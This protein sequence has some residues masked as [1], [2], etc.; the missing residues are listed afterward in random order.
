MKKVLKVV[1]ILLLVL[2]VAGA[3]GGTCYFF[4]TR[5]RAN[6]DVFDSFS[7]FIYGSKKEE[8]DAKLS[9]VT[10]FTDDRFDLVITT[11][12]K[13]E[14]IAIN[15]NYHLLNANDYDIDQHLI[16]DLINNVNEEQDRA[17]IMI[18]E[19]LI[20]TD[21]EYFD[22]DTG[23]ND[24]YQQMSRYFVSFSNLLD[25][26]NSEL[27]KTSITKNADAKF[28]LIDVYTNVCSNTFSNLVT[29][30]L[31][32]RRISSANNINLVNQYINFQNG[33]ITSTDTS[34]NFSYQ[35]NQ[36]IRNYEECDKDVF[37][38][39]LAQN[40][41]SIVNIDDNSSSLDRAVYY[42]KGVLN[43]Q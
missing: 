43:I 35:S 18:D 11:N 27:D 12:D 39:N 26:I 7:T 15:L 31:G 40:V 30:S 13:L 33:Y 37:A 8:F 22:R 41:S 42:F 6:V 24:L 9:R 23:A 20:K 10:E 4:Y 1:K 29:D 14:D 28:A 3:I 2:I 17:D 16:V 32:L 5:I 38:N 25:T 36:F 34:D 19:Y 21:S